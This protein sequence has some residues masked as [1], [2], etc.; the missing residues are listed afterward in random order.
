MILSAETALTQLSVLCYTFAV[1][2]QYKV[3]EI[4]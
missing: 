1:D 3:A 4:L 2:R